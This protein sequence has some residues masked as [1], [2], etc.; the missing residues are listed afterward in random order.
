MA[1]LMLPT[2]ASQ[3]SSVRLLSQSSQRSRGVLIAVVGS[4]SMRHFHALTSGSRGSRNAGEGS[5][6]SLDSG[7][8][9]DGTQASDASDASEASTSSVDSALQAV[10]RE[11]DEIQP[12]VGIAMRGWVSSAGLGACSCSRGSPPGSMAM[13]A[14]QSMALTADIEY[15]AFPQSPRCCPRGGLGE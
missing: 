9:S 6:A 13:Q 8:A 12:I 2:D 15:L 1:Q 4:W 5:E 7:E 3:L 10:W 11:L 14:F